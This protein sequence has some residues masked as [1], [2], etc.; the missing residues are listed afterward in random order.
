MAS[1]A[2]PTDCSTHVISSLSSDPCGPCVMPSSCSDNRR[3]TC[4]R[5]I[6]VCTHAQDNSSGAGPSTRYANWR[7]SFPYRAENPSVDGSRSWLT[8][9][10]ASFQPS[11]GAPTMF[12]AGTRAPSNETWPNSLVTPLIIFSGRCSMPG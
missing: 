10:I 4:R 3:R 8:T 11:P 1:V 5:S 7:T 9:V 6:S 12:S 2:W